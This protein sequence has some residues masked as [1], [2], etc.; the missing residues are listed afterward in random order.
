MNRR[1][2]IQ[3]V[4]AGT[5]IGGMA[6]WAP[7]LGQETAGGRTSHA[8][9]SDRPRAIEEVVVTAQRR[10]QT[11]QDTPVAVTAI[12]GEALERAAIADLIDLQLSVPSFVMYDGNR[13]STSTAFF[14]RGIGTSGN[15]A[16]LEGAVGF[17]VDGVYRPRSG[18]GLGDLVDVERIE[19]LRGPQGTLFGRNTSAGAISVV[20]RTPTDRFE[21]FGQIIAGNHDLRRVMGAVNV[22]LEAERLAVRLSGSHHTRDGYLKDTVT[23]ADYNDRDRWSLAASARYTPTETVEVIA[24]ADVSKAD[25]SCCQSVRLSNATSPAIGLLA[26][27]ATANGSTYPTSPTPERYATA[28]NGPVINDTDDYGLSLEV[29]VDLGGATVSS[30]TSYREF[31]SFTAND[32]DFSGADLVHQ[33]VDFSAETW[34]QELRLHGLFEG[35]GRGLDWLVGVYYADEKIGNRPATDFRPDMQ[36]Y[37]TALLG[38]NANLGALYA[39]L[40]NALGVDGEQSGTSWAAFTHN[41]LQLDHRWSLS[42]G[43]RYTKDEKKARVEV[44]TNGPTGQLPWAGLGLPFS[45]EHSYVDRFSDSAVT[46]TVAIQFDWTDDLMTYA[47]YSRGYKS[48]GFALGRDAA[49]QVYSANAACSASGTVAFAAVGSLPTIYLCDPLDPSFDSET[50]DSYELGVRST[51]AEGSLIL[52]VTAFY[53]EYDDLQLNTFNGFGFS[54]QNAGSAETRGVELESQWRTPLD[55]LTLGLNAAHI[56]ATF[57]NEVGA[58]M[59]GQPPVGGE[60]LPFTAKWS[61][62]ASAEYTRPIGRGNRAFSRVE[63]AYSSSRYMATRVGSTGEALKFPSFEVMSFSA[64]LAF[65]NGLE[66]SGYCRNCFNEQYPSLVF[67]SVAQGASRDWFLNAPRQYGLIVRQSF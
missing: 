6:C 4:V 3:S 2:G 21:G 60:P 65:A 10:E 63:Y 12:A 14:V 61:A 56:D 57:G 62:S 24:R 39:P 52:N 26:T 53:T 59:A 49:G 37:F 7:A 43:A 22:P 32:V 35:V 8:D 16:G 18:L 23:G 25:E 17:Y 5:M 58:V 38:G 55:G 31:D 47:S 30:L 41:I 20:T 48:G 33:S 67:N 66:V 11:L 64:G 50:A 19:L 34:S 27:L 28:V 1:N 54:V 15:D 13:P 36:P 9:A 45:A 42:F 40:E 51:H 46:G 44:F 29:N